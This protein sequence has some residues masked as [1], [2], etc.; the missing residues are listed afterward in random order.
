MPEAKLKNYGLTAL[1]DSIPKQPS[2]DHAARLLLAS[3][4]QISHEREQADEEKIQNA[5]LQK[6][7][8]TGKSCG[9]VF[10]NTIIS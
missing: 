9:S 2:I 1:T 7:H 3:L 6:E 5:Q 8:S 4:M 10:N